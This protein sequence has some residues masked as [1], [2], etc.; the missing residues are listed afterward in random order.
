MDISKIEAVPDTDTLEMTGAEVKALV[1]SAVEKAKHDADFNGG[2]PVNKGVQV[3]KDNQAEQ[4][5]AK[6][7]G[8]YILASDG[9]HHEKVMKMQSE[10]PAFF[11]SQVKTNIN[12]G[13]GAQGQYLVPTIW[14]NDIFQVVED[15]GFAR[16]LAKVIPM[17]SLTHNLNRGGSVTAAMVAEESAPT[18]LDTT[19]FF[20]QTALTA[21]RA[22]AAFLTSRE[23]LED[24]NP[25]LM[26]FMNTELGRA[27]A[28]L[29]DEQFFNGAG[30]GANHTGLIGTSGVNVQY[31][32][33]AS[34]SGK[35][36]FSNVSW[37]DLTRVLAATNSRIINGGFF[38]VPQTIAM[39]LAQEVDSVSG[40]PIWDNQRPIDSLTGLG[41]S[42]SAWMTPIG[43][44][45]V[46]VPDGC[47][48]SSAATKAGIIF[49]DF[50]KY[51]IFGDRSTLETQTFRESYNGTALSGVNRLAVEV[52]ERFGVAFPA[53]AGFTLIKT[54]TT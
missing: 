38:V 36:A 37:K 25:A 27:I 48:P 22:A 40:R 26:S 30:T 19:S 9:L 15:Y 45:M 1:A 50:S 44:P 42:A 13:T 34:N 54:S 14:E 43:K 17:R 4:V 2:I 31:F 10:Q 28:Q 32:G 46:V 47:F 11:G 41:V 3:G 24:A 23:A 33:G 7:I 6:F 49:G 18:P 51:G 52:S 8:E 5:K 20:A 39:Y 35:T 16:K 53:P 21:K 12:E 29:E